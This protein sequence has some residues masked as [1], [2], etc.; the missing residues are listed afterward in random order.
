MKVFEVDKF[1]CEEGEKNEGSPSTNSY[2]GTVA[3]PAIC[4]PYLRHRSATLTEPPSVQS[5][6]ASKHTGNYHTIHAQSQSCPS[7]ESTNPF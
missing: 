1:V 2:N 3:K 7:Q 5:F 6:C 4:V